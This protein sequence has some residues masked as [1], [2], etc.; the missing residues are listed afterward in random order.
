MNTNS[1]LI[2]FQ[3]LNSCPL[4]ILTTAQFLNAQKKRKLNESCSHE[5]SEQHP[6]LRSSKY[7]HCCGRSGSHIQLK[8]C[9][10]FNEGV[11]RKAVCTKCIKFEMKMNLSEL[12]SFQCSHCEGKCPAR[13]R[14]HS[15]KISNKKRYIKTENQ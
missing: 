3:K 1:F 13:A 15:Y 4:S 10:N 11:C 8:V 6:Q 5:S 12:D 7:C 9:G 14:C 2:S